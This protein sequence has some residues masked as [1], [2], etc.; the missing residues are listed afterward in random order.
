VEPSVTVGSGDDIVNQSVSGIV[1]STPGTY[2]MSI[3]VVAAS[4][5]NNRPLNDRV[6]IAVK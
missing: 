5:G 2:E 4:S 6:A 1:T 3:A